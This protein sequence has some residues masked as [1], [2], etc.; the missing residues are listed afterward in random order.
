LIPAW[1]DVAYT[2]YRVE[3][4]ERWDRQDRIERGWPCPPP[5]P[6]PVLL[7]RCWRSYRRRLADAHAKAR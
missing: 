4:A 1:L 5:E 6:W 2:V 3:Q 7:R